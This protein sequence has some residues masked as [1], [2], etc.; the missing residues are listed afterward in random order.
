M[1]FGWLKKIFRKKN[2][3]NTNTSDLAIIDTSFIRVPKLSKLSK[4]EKEKVLELYNKL[5]IGNDIDLVK[6]SNDLLEKANTEREMLL[7]AMSRYEEQ[8]N[9]LKEEYKKNKQIPS[10]EIY[11]L[12]KLSSL[13]YAI[14]EKNIISIRKELELKLVALDMYIK[15][16]EKRK[17]NFLDVFGRAER[18][19]C[20]TDKNKLLSERERLLTSIKIDE[21]ILTIIR[22]DIK[23]NQRLI[24]YHDLL[25]KLQNDDTKLLR[26]SLDDSMYR[27]SKKSFFSIKDEYEDEVAIKVGNKMKGYPIREEA[28]N[29]DFCSQMY[30][31]LKETNGIINEELKEYV[32]EVARH[33]GED[34]T[35]KDFLDV[36]PDEF[37][38]KLYEIVAKYSHKR[39]LY[40]YEH[41]NDYKDYLQD[42]K[43]LINKCE[44]TSKEEW[45]SSLLK[46]KLIY[47][48]KELKQYLNIYGNDRDLYFN[49][50]YDEQISPPMEEQLRK[51]YFKLLFLYAISN[52]LD[53]LIFEIFNNSYYGDGLYL[54]IDIIYN[55]FAMILKE[56]S[57]DVFNKYK[58]MRTFESK[59]NG[60]CKNEEK[61]KEIL[62][63]GEFLLNIL[64]GNYDK[65]K[66]YIGVYEDKNNLYNKTSQR[67]KLVSYLNNS[68]DDY[69]NLRGIS[70]KTFSISDEESM[71]IEDLYYLLKIVGINKVMPDICFRN[72]PNN[73][74]L[75]SN[76]RWNKI[77]KEED[78]RIFILPKQVRFNYL[79]SD[80]NKPIMTS[81]DKLNISDN[82][83]A[84][85]VSNFRQLNT[86]Y[87][88]LYNDENNIKYL[89]MNEQLYEKYKERYD[90]TMYPHIIIVPNDTR[91]V[92]LSKYLDQELAKKQEQTKIL[93]KTL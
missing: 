8:Y 83:I 80:Q 21:N 86:I 41:R 51:S 58:V 34:C 31:I 5:I 10:I 17:Y 44:S 3:S 37:L 54:N 38:D 70:K 65:T 57:V 55:E 90:E 92:E 77:E 63:N 13:E 27:L 46:E 84:I 67:M 42:M 91:Y 74:Y 89:I 25:K 29:Y 23:E 30:Y 20:F 35:W 64:N 26:K 75:L 79:F 22:K 69:N 53:N 9:F 76:I 18:I 40:V 36:V 39:D 71:E 33:Y 11:N 2:L 45:D 59:Y 78:N 72:L 15:K 56:L 87:N 19:K 24:I 60:D 50:P 14:I 52:G 81:L 47:Y 4:E 85:Y 73:A 66:L 16:E 32:L 68:L 93:S 62:E 7:R 6:Y 48:T 82:N 49:E 1:D 28:Y 61:T 12:G 43:E 88:A